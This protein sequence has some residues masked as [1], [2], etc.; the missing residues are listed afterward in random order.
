[1][2]STHVGLCCN[3]DR[4]TWQ[5]QFEGSLH[6]FSMPI[7]QSRDAINMS[8]QRCTT[9]RVSKTSN[10][11]KTHCLGYLTNVR[12]FQYDAAVKSEDYEIQLPRAKD[13]SIAIRFE[14][15]ATNWDDGRSCW[16]AMTGLEQIQPERY[17][18]YGAN[19]VLASNARF[20]VYT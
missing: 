8:R 18:R 7:F 9:C 14:L 16:H 1:M 12:R 5:A 3:E 13:K 15:A 6:P 2:S 4:L 17:L 20:K 10:I 11:E 19:R